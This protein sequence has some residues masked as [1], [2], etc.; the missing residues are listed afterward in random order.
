MAYQTSNLL[1]RKWLLQMS[2]WEG[3]KWSSL[4]LEGAS[5]VQ[6]RITFLYGNHWSGYGCNVRLSIQLLLHWLSFCCQ[7]QPV[8]MCRT[9]LS[10]SLSLSLS[11]SS[12][13]LDSSQRTGR[14]NRRR[15]TFLDLEIMVF[16]KPNRSIARGVQKNW[17]DGKHE[18]FLLS[19]WNAS[20]DMLVFVLIL[21]DNDCVTYLLRRITVISIMN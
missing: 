19:W 1:L 18:Y 6:A 3:L 16:L 2:N 9:H 14:R 20:A 13:S 17:T 10:L 7:Y 21:C 11:R 12:I 8:C 4:Y 15:K 5:E